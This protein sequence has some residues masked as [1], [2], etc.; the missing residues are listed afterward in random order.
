MVRRMVGWNF[1]PIVAEFFPGICFVF[2][3]HLSSGNH[4]DYVLA[5]IPNT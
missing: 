4:E 1:G 2:L 3:G 5:R